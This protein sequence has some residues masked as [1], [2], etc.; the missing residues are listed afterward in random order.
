MKVK[1]QNKILFAI[2]VLFVMAVSIF[3]FIFY[4][5]LVEIMD[6]RRF[7]DETHK[8]YIVPLIKG[9]SFVRKQRSFAEKEAV[10]NQIYQK[11]VFDD[12]DY[13]VLYD[14]LD[15]IAKEN[16][17]ESINVTERKLPN[18]DRKL[19]VDVEILSTKGTF[20][21]YL[22]ALERSDYYFQIRELIIQEIAATQRI[23]K[24]ETYISD[25]AKQKVR[26][27]EEVKEV[28][29]I[30]ALIRLFVYI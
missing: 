9:T 27:I 3:V 7:V 22:K 4:P 13:L 12:A 19:E 11:S 20:K 23:R 18:R 24:E 15:K 21:E 10:I 30:R 2:A 28:P 16:G 1:I 14:L 25:N 6:L 29:K 17:V 5:S 8:Q 26:V